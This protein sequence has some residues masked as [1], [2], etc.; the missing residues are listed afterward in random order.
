MRL[1]FLYH[2][3]CIHTGGSE[4]LNSNSGT[5]D[6]GRKW[7]VVFNAGKTQLALNEWSNNTDAIDG[8]VNGSVPEEKLFSKMLGL[9]FFSKL[10]WSSYIISITKTASKNIGAVI[11]L[12]SFFLLRFLCI[13]LNLP[14]VGASSCYL[15][16]L[17]KLQKG[18]CR[19]VSLSLAAS[20]EPLAHY[21]NIVSLLLW[22]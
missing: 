3:Q 10:D 1:G 20:L 5:V 16:M 11:L 14:W 22:I 19:A 2:Q 8:K 12:L 13:S 4:N 15:E 18:I 21:R 17:N 7:L 9:P 6:R